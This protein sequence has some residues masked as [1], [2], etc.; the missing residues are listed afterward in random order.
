MVMAQKIGP[1]HYQRR[2]LRTRL[3]I[4]LGAMR[5]FAERGYAE[6]SMEDISVEAGCSKGGLYHHFRTKTDVLTAVARRMASEHALSAPYGESAA[7]LGLTP[8]A[9]G[10]LLVDLW[11]E[12]VR[13]LELR[14][15]EL[16]AGLGAVAQMVAAGALIDARTRHPETMDDAEEARAA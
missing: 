3:S 6:T 15:V 5:L 4:T 2:A 11:A 8:D 10:R 16:G 1:V 9:Y 13:T 12:A 7:K 14:E